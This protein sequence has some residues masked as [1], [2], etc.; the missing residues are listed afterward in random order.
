MSWTQAQQKYALS[1]KGKEARQ[2][3]QV[4]PKG[5]EARKRYLANRKSKSKEVK[6]TEQIIPVENIV[7]EIKNEKK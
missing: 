1:L 3:Y 5:I 7:E 4:S 6:Q 2:R